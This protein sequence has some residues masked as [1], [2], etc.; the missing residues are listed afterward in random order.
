MK[1][2]VY[3]A[4]FGGRDTELKEPLN[5]DPSVRFVCIT[6]DNTF[7]SDVW[8]IVLV[9]S[10][11]T[12]GET[13]REQSYQYKLMPHLFFPDADESLWMD[14]SFQLNCNPCVLFNYL[15][16][17]PIWAF[18]HNRRKSI[19]EEADIIIPLF[20]LEEK[21]LRYRLAQFRAR[22][23][24]ANDLVS[25]GFLV[26]KH[27]PQIKFMNQCWW[28]EYQTNTK[29]KD[30]IFLNYAAHRAGIKIGKLP[31]VFTENPFTTWFKH[32]RRLGKEAWD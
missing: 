22:G 16:E 9:P 26:R 11:G 14:G 12:E 18:P 5:P 32:P 2:V 4:I 3:T 27:T 25:A 6:D 21:P 13:P 7:E 10:W 15:Q 30:Q 19:E 8:E 24:R 17:H 20:R 31:G 28:A 23:Y 1:R 29:A